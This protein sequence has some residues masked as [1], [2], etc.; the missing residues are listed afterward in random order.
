MSGEE[1]L[2]PLDQAE[3]SGTSDNGTQAAADASPPAVG[4]VGPVRSPRSRGSRSGGP[5]PC[6]RPSRRRLRSGRVSAV[7][8]RSSRST[9]VADRLAGL[10]VTA[11]H[12][13]PPRL[14]GRWRVAPRA[15]RRPRPRCPRRPPPARGPGCPSV[16]WAHG[17]DAVHGERRALN[18]DASRRF[19]VSRSPGSALTST[20][21]HPEAVNHAPARRAGPAD[22]H[23]TGRRLDVTGVDDPE[24]GLPHGVDPTDGQTHHG[25][26][27]GADEHAPAGF[28]QQPVETTRAQEGLR[29]QARLATGEEGAT[30]G[31]LQASREPP[32]RARHSV[33]HRRAVLLWLPSTPV[34][35]RSASICAATPRRA[36]EQLLDPVEDGAAM[37]VRLLVGAD[38]LELGRRQTLEALDHLRRRQAVVAGDG[39][40]PERAVAV[41]AGPGAVHLRLGARGA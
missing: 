28:G 5:L 22:T 15:A 38:L 24:R 12:R 11:R 13:P 2:E 37:A 3:G 23:T 41:G 31:P 17:R 39:E 20:P 1:L 18:P 4:V 33:R 32:D 25:V 29:R 9:A 19:F 26:V 35:P 30:A 34:A 27:D 10:D 6:A 7:S 40:R 14:G 36:G 8:S 16:H 21:R